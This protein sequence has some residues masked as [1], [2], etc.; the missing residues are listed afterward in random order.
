MVEIATWDC[1]TLREWLNNEFLNDAF[2]RDEQTMIPIVDVKDDKNPD[3]E[4]EQGADTQDGIFLMSVKEVNKYFKTD[5][6]RKCR[7]TAYAIAQGVSVNESEKVGNWWLRTFGSRSKV[8]AS[9]VSVVSVVDGYGNIVT[10]GQ[11]VDLIDCGIRPAMWISL[12]WYNV[13][14]EKYNE[15]IAHM[16]KGE[17]VEA[18]LDFAFTTWGNYKDSEQKLKEA[19]AALK[20]S[21]PVVPEDT[22]GN[23][24][25]GD[26]K[27]L[28]D[29][30]VPE[31]TC[32]TNENGEV[33]PI[34]PDDEKEEETTGTEK[35]EA[36]T[37][38]SNSGGNVHIKVPETEEEMVHINIPA[39]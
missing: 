34:I 24:G 23:S 9:N 29:P 12:E 17:Y 11:P 8:H 37:E 32:E 13:M 22:S 25:N 10:E 38:P 5:D 3:Y 15:G 35:E 6:E 2:A 4:S 31:D 21:A 19:Q 1:C 36:S 30:V 18:V 39:P 33:L 26:E 7:P 14:E 27:P 20:S 16:K 28:P